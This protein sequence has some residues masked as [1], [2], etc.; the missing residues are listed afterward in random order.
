MEA[1]SVLLKTRLKHRGHQAGRGSGG[2]PFKSR[3]LDL[4][5]TLTTATH[6]GMLTQDRGTHGSHRLLGYVG[7]H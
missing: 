7:I 3:L 4:T 5:L 2:L 1:P 6:G